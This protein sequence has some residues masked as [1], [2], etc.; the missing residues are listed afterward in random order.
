MSVIV[1]VSKE[2][3]ID[4]LKASLEPG[5][6]YVLP[7]DV[8]ESYIKGGYLIEYIDSLKLPFKNT[9]DFSGKKILVLTMQALGDGLM[10]TPFLRFL[11]EYFR[12]IH[13]T[14]ETKKEFNLLKNCPYVDEFVYSPLELSFVKSFDT[15]LN[16]YMLVGSP[17]F[18]LN[19][20]ASYYFKLFGFNI[21]PKEK[22]IPYVYIDEEKD[23]YIKSLFDEYRNIYK[24]PI[25]GFHFSASSPHRMPPVDIFCEAI[26][27]LSKFF[28]IV[29]S[30]PKAHQDYAK[31]IPKYIPKSIDISSHIKDI[32]Y[33]PPYVKNLD[34]LISVET[35]LP[36]IAAAVGTPTLVVLG[37]GSFKN[38][39]DYGVPHLKAL[40]MNYKGQ[41]CSSPCQLHIS[42]KCPEAIVKQT[43]L[44]PCF[45]NLNS[46][47]LKESFYELLDRVTMARFSSKEHL[48]ALN[49]SENGA[50]HTRAVSTHFDSNEHSQPLQS[51]ENCLQ[52][53][54]AAMTHF[55][56]NE[57]A[58]PLKSS[59][60]GARHTTVKF[61]TSLTKVLK[62]D[63]E[64]EKEAF[65][66]IFRML[67]TAP[68]V[69]YFHEVG[70][71]FLNVL[72]HLENIMSFVI[73]T[74]YHKKLLNKDLKLALITKG[75]E[76]I[77]S[78]LFVNSF[79]ENNIIYVENDYYK[80]L[81]HHLGIKSYV[82][83][84]DNVIKDVDIVL[85][86]S[87]TSEK[88]MDLKTYKEHLRALLTHFNSKEHAQPLNSSENGYK[89]AT[90]HKYA[91]VQHTNKLSSAK[92]LFS[93]VFNK[94]RLK[95]TIQKG[96]DIYQT[97]FDKQMIE[98]DKDD[99]KDM[100]ITGLSL[101]APDFVNTFGDYAL[102]QQISAHNQV[103]GLLKN[104]KKH[105]YIYA[106]TNF[107]PI[108]IKYE[109]TTRFYS[110]VEKSYLK[111]NLSVL[112][113][114]EDA[115]AICFIDKAYKDMF[116]EAFKESIFIDL[117]SF[118]K[119][120]IEKYIE[121]YTDIEEIWMIGE[122][123]DYFKQDQNF[124]KALL[125]GPKIN[126]L[127]DKNP[128]SDELYL[129]TFLSLLRDFP[130]INFH[131][132][133]KG[134]YDILGKKY[135]NLFYFDISN[136]IK[137]PSQDVKNHTI[138]LLILSSSYFYQHKYS[139]IDVEEFYASYLNNFSKNLQ[140]Q[141]L[142]FLKE[143]TG[144]NN[145]YYEDKEFLD[146]YKD[147][148]NQS[149]SLNYFIA[150]EVK[151]VASKFTKNIL[152]AGML[153]FANPKSLKELATEHINA[154]RYMPD[155]ILIKENPEFLIKNS[156]VVLYLDALDSFQKIPSFIL[157]AQ[158]PIILKYQKSLEYAKNLILVK[159][160]EELLGTI[161]FILSH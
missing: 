113:A 86:I 112:S 6:F 39:Y 41:V 126:L 15:V 146:F 160:I 124:L 155:I 64:Q 141:I 130:S 94:N 110:F 139:E 67:S 136:Y 96:Q 72:P 9:R 49:S 89:S 157:K 104:D 101:T 1:K 62:Q 161:G 77:P 58:Q 53:T 142:D 87:L 134:V 133:H 43:N 40:E 106:L 97:P 145:L 102:F 48:S 70:L 71:A 35:V 69:S 20:V 98:I 27:S 132:T 135:K 149:A 51:S 147:I 7:K 93:F 81:L 24:K 91:T 36:H 82:F 30:Y 92:Y 46:L 123:L 127:I 116:Y 74:L 5:K 2:L 32:E 17:M 107:K 59:E 154:S 22:L 118:D 84:Q 120:I 42:Q 3:Y 47:S 103:F 122:W 10:L 26:G 131:T 100:Y 76:T 140:R 8:Y 34:A 128:F 137:Q 159:N 33:I 129:N 121:K 111:P 61:D 11:K 117:S 143:K 152:H 68:I 83:D 56:A 85:D 150:Q 108:D 52:H 45:S 13:I 90:P 75:A 37:P 31:E 60:N 12:N 4:D 54:R 80:K 65:K 99:I 63:L 95:N 148:I 38:I 44:S 115:K 158:K 14:L 29:Y 151:N 55:G 114:N 88:P 57:Q 153:N 50:R 79:W 109:D 23:K 125:F 156:K 144:K 28:T 21:P 138:D 78:A 18:D 25:L 73:N 19:L 119:T 105:A 16:L 66:H